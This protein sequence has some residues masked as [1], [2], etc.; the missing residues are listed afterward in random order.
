MTD[1]SMTHTEVQHK[2][3]DHYWEAVNLAL[4]QIW[5]DQEAYNATFSVKHKIQPYPKD[6]AQQL[7]RLSHPESQLALDYL[8][9]PRFFGI[10]TKRIARLLWECSDNENF[11]DAPQAY[12]AIPKAYYFATEGKGSPE[13]A[14]DHQL[15]HLFHQIYYLTIQFMGTAFGYPIDIEDEGISIFLQEHASFAALMTAATD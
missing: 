9:A 12:S 4:Q 7:A 8:V 5:N 13:L 6:W 2:L 14:G 3:L 11:G 10:S 15:H 1:S